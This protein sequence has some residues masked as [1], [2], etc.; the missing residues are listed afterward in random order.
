[1]AS[2]LRVTPSPTLPTRGRVWFGTCGTDVPKTPA[3]TSPL[4]GE[5][6]RGVSR[7]AGDDAGVLRG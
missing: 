7:T 6:G 3:D 1:M 5:D 4:A 2:F